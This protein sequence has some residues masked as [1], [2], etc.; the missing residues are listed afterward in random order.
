MK[1][2]REHTAVWTG[3]AMLVWGGTDFSMYNDGAQYTPSTDTWE[4]LPAVELAGRY[5]HTAV[6]TGWEM[7]VWGGTYGFPYADGA[8]YNPETK[9]WKRLPLVEN[10]FAARNS[11]SML[12]TGER[13]IIW[14]GITMDGFANDGVIG[15]FYT[16]LYLPTV[17]RAFGN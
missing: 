6:W 13:I 4:M 10:G 15:N 8:R 2:R 11:H 16:N 9:M 5:D 7:V 17:F 14:G 1:G 12:W 3:T